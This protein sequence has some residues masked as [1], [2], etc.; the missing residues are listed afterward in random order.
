ML[1]KNLKESN[2]IFPWGE[3]YVDISELEKNVYQ[4][5]M[6][7]GRR[8]MA[9]TIEQTDQKLAEQRDRRVYR[10]K[11]YRSTTIK[12]VMGEVS[13]RRHVY[14]IEGNHSRPNATI[15]LLD[16]KMGL[17]TVGFFSDT[18][19]MMALEEACTKSYRKAAETLST[20]TGLA[21]SHESV[22]RIV[23]KVGT[24]RRDH[25]DT[26]SEAAFCKLSAGSYETPILYEEMDGVYLSLQG[27]DR[28]E[29]NTSNK[30]M[31]V[32]IAYSGV[33]EN[34][35]RRTLANKVAF[36]AFES[37][38]AFKNHTEGVIADFYDV[39]KIQRRIFNTDGGPWMKRQLVP[40][41]V[42]QLDIFHRNKAVRAYIDDP[43]IQKTIFHL[44]KHKKVKAALE[45]IE[46]S[47]ESTLDPV[48]QEKRRKLFSFFSN[49][50]KALVPFYERSSR[51]SLPSP[52]AGQVPATCGSMESNIFTIIGH[53]MKNNRTSWSISG[54]NNLAALLSLYSTGMLRKGLHGWFSY[55]LPETFVSNIKFPLSAEEIPKTVGKGYE[56]PLDNIVPID[57]LPDAMQLW[58]KPKNPDYYF[59]LLPRDWSLVPRAS[60]DPTKC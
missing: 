36:A 45:V 50:S 32:S 22:W 9:R 12:T 18:V 23:Q 34:G 31:K 21:I 42:Y 26:L 44:L 39:S 11:G 29:S 60:K 35:H 53:R 15:H 20:K 19:C 55:N 25:V 13:Y 59:E 30:E 58:L 52:N 57:N 49:F 16:E 37:P 40:H 56:G 3:E 8:I 10:D 46:A 28:R 17:D 33:F 6:E 27:K 38:N 48:E 51:K 4:Y 14:S 47:I 54:A 43:D 1:S 41:C 7:L 2:K 5:V 24:W